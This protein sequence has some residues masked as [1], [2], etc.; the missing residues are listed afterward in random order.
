VATMNIMIAGQHIDVTDALRARVTEKVGRLSRHFDQVQKAQALL[1]VEPYP[2]RNQVAEVTLW[3]NGVVLRGEEAS[4]DMY[5]S[6]DL[7][8]DK[9]EKQIAK[10]RS[11]VIGY[12]RTLSSR[13]KQQ[14]A[15]AAAR[16]AAAAAEGV[17][18]EEAASDAVRI[19]RRKRFE[20]KPM[21]PED[22][23]VQMELLG[24]TFFMFRNAETL[25][26]NVVYRRTDG[27][28]GLLEPE[29]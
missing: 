22:A 16:Q 3:A 4:E 7:V 27:S 18:A 11:K 15:A 14:E 24:H 25:D 5:A 20:L 21:T 13:R 6:I 19:A 2:G 26:V 8:V 28:Y 9:L 1:R 23:A 29:G 12:R 17:P 10:F